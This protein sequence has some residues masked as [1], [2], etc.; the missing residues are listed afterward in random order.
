LDGGKNTDE[1]LL[2]SRKFNVETYIPIADAIVSNLEKV[3]RTNGEI[4]EKIGFWKA[5]IFGL[6]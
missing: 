4:F 6:L 5:F 2:G 1:L 3:V